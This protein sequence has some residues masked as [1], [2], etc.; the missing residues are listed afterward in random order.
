MLRIKV[1]ISI[2]VAFSLVA[3]LI[4]VNESRTVS[5]VTRGESAARI[6]QAQVA[7]EQRRSLRNFSILAKAEAVAEYKGVI[8][9]VKRWAAPQ[10]GQKEENAE[11]AKVDNDFLKTVHNE[12]LK[13][14]AAAMAGFK[15][16]ADVRDRSSLKN[17]ISSPPDYLAVVDAEGRVLA[18]K[19]TY[20]DEWDRIEGRILSVVKNPKNTS[21]QDSRLDVW[22]LGKTPLTVG[23]A[24]IVEN[25]L[26]LGG[27]IVGHS[28]NNEAK[29]D[30]DVLG[31][32]IDV[33][34]HVKALNAQAEP[35][36]FVRT[37]VTNGMT[38]AVERFFEISS[39]VGV[40]NF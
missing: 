8:R 28:L 2:V 11:D 36:N 26:T 1:V 38:S 4:Y 14:L 17:R 34:Y 5:E 27:V 6:D 18:E 7:L 9:E 30:S 23:L 25:G 20:T 37:T 10:P 16:I 15:S 22:F 40:F 12:L 33:V 21:S 39:L 13:E 19:G 29:G 24:P 35:R 31:V 3:G 32:G